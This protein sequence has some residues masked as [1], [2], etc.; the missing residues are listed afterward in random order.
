[1]LTI[2][3]NDD[4]DNANSYQRITAVLKSPYTELISP[5]CYVNVQP[6]GTGINNSL[7]VFSDT[8]NAVL[9]TDYEKQLTTMITSL[10]SCGL[11]VYYPSTNW[12][13]Q[14]VMK[15]NDNTANTAYSYIMVD[16]YTLNLDH[17]YDYYAHLHEMAH[18]YEATQQHYGFRFAAWTDGNATNL[19]KDAMDKM[20]VN[21]RDKNGYD[22]IDQMYQTN[23][24]FLTQDNKNNFEAYY[25][26]ATG[27][28]ATL[29]GYH[30][31]DF[32]QD[33]YGSDVVY[34]ILDKVYAANI[35]ENYG[36]NSTYDKQ[37][38]DCIKAVTYQNVFQLFVD[39]CVN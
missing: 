33:V 39:Y 9:A 2:N 13:R 21:Y 24:S 28:E 20:S 29:I 4:P 15:L 31:T 27:W 26:N 38:T 18:F 1:M 23:Y 22:L 16:A 10:N 7:V 34:R 17:Y 3:N 11:N 35:P 19:A 5:Y 25:L 32:L 37:F 6:S 36:R 14:L 30:F 12:N 8:G